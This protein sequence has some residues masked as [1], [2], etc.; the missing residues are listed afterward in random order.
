MLVAVGAVVAGAAVAGTVDVDPVPPQAT[1]RRAAPAISL[2]TTGGLGD[3][4]L[5][6]VG[7]GGDGLGQVVDPFLV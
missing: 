5:H 6:I 7:F 4:F 1:I 2:A 3:H